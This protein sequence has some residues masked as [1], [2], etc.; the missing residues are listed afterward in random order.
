MVFRVST[1]GGGVLNTTP[2]LRPQLAEFWA[3]F[4][5]LRGS[6]LFLPFPRLSWCRS[7]W[8]SCTR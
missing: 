6:T 3:S 5:G 8:V 1:C 7:I 2:Q 4:L